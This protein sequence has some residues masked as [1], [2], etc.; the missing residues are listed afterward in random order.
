MFG[1]TDL[2]FREAYLDQN[3]PNLEQLNDVSDFL[4]ALIPAVTDPT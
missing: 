3:T 2:K 4:F 1:A